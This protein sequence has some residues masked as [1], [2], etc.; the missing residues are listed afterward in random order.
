MQLL[1]QI[2]NIDD[3]YKN[4]ATFETKKIFQGPGIIGRTSQCDWVLLDPRN[5]ISGIHAKIELIQNEF[6]ITDM[7]TNGLFL[8]ETKERIGKGNRMPLKSGTLLRINPYLIE[9]TI[10]TKEAY[11]SKRK[12]MPFQGNFTPRASESHITPQQ[13]SRPLIG[14][15]MLKLKQPQNTPISSPVLSKSTVPVAPPIMPYEPVAIPQTM[16]PML[17]SATENEIKA[18]QQTLQQKVQA[19]TTNDSPLYSLFLKKFGH[20]EHELLHSSPE[21]IIEMASHVLYECISGLMRVSYSRR[22][23]KSEL[24]FSR[25]LVL[26]EYLNPFK[27]YHHIKE[28][29][30]NIFSTNKD[31]TWKNPVTS[32]R[33]IFEEDIISHGDAIKSGCEAVIKKVLSVIS[34]E[35]I[36]EKVEKRFFSKILSTKHKAECWDLFKE[37]FERISRLVEEDKLIVNFKDDFEKAYEQRSR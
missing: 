31:S 28:I 11:P 5:T 32:V 19:Y 4:K 16:E 3:V 30:L 34:P 1:L 8:G 22:K 26:S 17:A 15:D 20:K 7:S 18:P 9:A 23:L 27:H 37:E 12:P 2:K 13:L 24:N 10:I 33:E 29:T 14:M 25:S 21:Y 6:Y 36:E 35:Q